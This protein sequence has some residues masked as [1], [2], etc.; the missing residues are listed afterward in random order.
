M[1]DTTKEKMDRVAVATSCGWQ[2]RCRTV[3]ERTAYLLRHSPIPFDVKFRVGS[4]DV[5]EAVIEAHRHVLAIGSEYFFSLFYG[6]FPKKAT[7]IEVF[8]RDPTA[9]TVMVQYAATW[10]LC[11]CTDGGCDMYQPA[12][13]GMPTQM[14]WT[15]QSSML[16][17]S[18]PSKR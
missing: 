10:L 3:K 4:L 15:P 17:L 6:P 1:C 11:F 13:A 9:F 12:I 7:L 16:T 5:K 14:L 2:G 8:D 18:W